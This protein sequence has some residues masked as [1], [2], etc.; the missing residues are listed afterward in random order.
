MPTDALALPEEMVMRRERGPS[1]PEQAPISILEL[2]D[3]RVMLDS[4]LA[5]LFQVETRVFNQA[6]KRNQDRF[7]AGWAFELTSVELDNLISQTVISSSGWGGRRTLPWVFTEHGV[8]LAASILSSDRAKAVMQHVVEVFVRARRGEVVRTGP[9]AARLGSSMTNGGGAFSK[10]L[11]GMI[12]RLMDAMVDQDN[13]RSLQDE[14]QAILRESIDH[15]RAKLCRAGFENEEIAA[16]AAKLLAEAEATK[17]TAAKTRAE[18]DEIMLRTLARK[19]A[20]VLEAEQ[21][22]TRGEVAGFL[23]VLK[24]LG[25]A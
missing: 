18:A 1:A 7:P 10:R 12:E 13:Q 19:L 24:R 8:V 20:M 3:E 17:A 11:Q 6:F 2:R 25:K 23:A 22:I 4:D 5:A 9:F 15:I 14:A 16:R 21:A